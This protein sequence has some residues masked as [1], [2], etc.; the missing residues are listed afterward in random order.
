MGASLLALAKSIYY[1]Y[2]L[3][4]WHSLFKADCVA[5]PSPHCYSIPVSQ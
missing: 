2:Y 5:T 3:T 1:T 4:K